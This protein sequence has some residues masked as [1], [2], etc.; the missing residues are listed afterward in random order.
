MLLA[1][2]IAQHRYL[3]SIT[4]SDCRYMFLN[5][6][7]TNLM[8]PDSS[9]LGFSQFCRAIQTNARVKSL[10]IHSSTIGDDVA[11]KREYVEE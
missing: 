7:V 8:S 10:P 2:E 4:I 1:P 11:A 5:M 3:H 9:N 6:D